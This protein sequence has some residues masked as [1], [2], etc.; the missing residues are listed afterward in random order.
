MNKKILES[1]VTM[2][3]VISA[4]GAWARCGD[5]PRA[6]LDQ[7]I[8]SAEG[9]GAATGGY[10]LEMWVTVVDETGKI[11]HVATSGDS[12]LFAGNKECWAAA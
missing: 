11:C 2:I 4:T 10:G 12:G 3:L 6:I 7:A 5:V 9:A 1:A 8:G